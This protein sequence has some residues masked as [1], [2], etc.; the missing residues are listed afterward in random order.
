MYSWSRWR[1]AVPAAQPDAHATDAMR[2]R[3]GDLATVERHGAGVGTEM[4]CDQV[5]QRGFAGAIRADDRGNRLLV[6]ADLL[7][8]LLLNLGIVRDTPAEGSGYGVDYGLA[9]AGGGKHPW[10]R[11]DGLLGMGGRRARPPLV[12]DHTGGHG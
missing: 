5:E 4:S 2:R 12:D 6:D 1:A 7:H 11:R 9:T 3:A 8:H 10:L